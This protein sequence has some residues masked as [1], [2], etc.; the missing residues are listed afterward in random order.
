MKYLLTLACFLFTFSARA[1]NPP[2]P[3]SYK[4][5][6]TEDQQKKVVDSLKEL[7]D[8][9]ESKAELEFTEPIIIIVD[10]EQRIYI[11]GG[12]K[13][14]LELKLKLGDTIR[15]DLAVQLPIKV[16]YREEPPD[17]PFRFRLRAQAG[18]LVPE[19]IRSIRDEQFEL[20]YDLGVGIDWV[21][22]EAFNLAFYIG[23][24]GFGLG[25]GIDITKNFGVT[26]NFVVKYESIYPDFEPT[27]NT[28]IY[29]A[30][31]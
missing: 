1:Q 22:Y 10:W 29:F 14:P 19:I 24:L 30:F 25:P 17:P 12:E 8:I 21:H 16:S 6:L 5:C 9:K 4:V 27:V 31:N 28:G 11:N 15:R 18:L 23:T 13:K 2:C 3:P 20:P 7:K 26:A